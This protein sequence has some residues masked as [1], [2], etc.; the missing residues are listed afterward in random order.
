MFAPATSP[1]AARYAAYV[2]PAPV[3]TWISPLRPAAYARHAAS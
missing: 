3:G 1:S 2:F